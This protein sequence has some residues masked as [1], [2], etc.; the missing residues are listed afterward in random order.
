MYDFILGG[1]ASGKTTHIYKELIEESLRC[2]GQSFYLFVPEQYTL[3]AQQALA[4]MSP[5]GGILNIDVLSFTLLSYRVFSELGVKKPDILDDMTKS[6]LIRK[7]MRLKKDELRIYARKT[8]SQGFMEEIKQAIAEFCQYDIDTDRLR[9]LSGEGVSRRLSDKLSD[10]AA[11]YECFSDLLREG[12]CIPEEL[13]KLLLSLLPRSEYL[14]G[15]RVYFD[16]FTGYTPIQLR[17]IAHIL[18][19]AER[20]SF[21]VTIPKAELGPGRSRDAGSDTDIYWLSRDSISSIGELGDRGGIAHGEDLILDGTR[22]SPEVLVRDFEDPLRETEELARIIKKTVLMDESCRYRDIAVAVSDQSTYRDL[23]RNAFDRAGIPFFM[24]ENASSDQ[25][26]SASLLHAVLQLVIRG[27]RYDDLSRY[28]KNPLIKRAVDSSG[29]YTDIFDNYIRAR[30]IRGRRACEAPFTD[31]WRG[32]EGLDLD[33]LNAYRE[34]LMKPVLELHDRLREQRTIGD[35]AISLK[36]YMEAAGAEAADRELCQRLRSSGYVNEAAAEESFM[37]QC[38]LLLQRMSELMGEERSSI[39]AF[40]ELL[41][42]GLSSLKA[43]LIPQSMDMLTVGDLRRSRFDGIRQLYVLGANDG[44]IPRASEVRGIFTQQERD[45]LTALGLSLAPQSARLVSSENFYL[46]LLLHKP[47]DRLYIS[48]PRED[49]E[50]REL[51]PAGFIGELGERHELAEGETFYA[52]YEDALSAFSGLLMKEGE[53]MEELRALFDLLSGD[54]RTRDR[55]GTLLK[56]AL[57]RYEGA[58]MDGETARELYGGVLYGSVTRMESFERCAYAHFLRYG[59]RLM[60]RQEYDVEAADMGNLYHA[61]LELSFRRLSEQGLE[62]RDV[63]EEELEGIGRA[64]VEEVSSEYNGSIMNASARNVFLKEKVGRITRR[65]L[66][67]LRTQSRKGS[68]R[69]LSCELPFRLRDEGLELH[70][71]IDRVDVCDD[72]IDTYVRVIDYKSGR[73]RFDLSLIYH[74]LQMQ[75]ITYMD[76]AIG[77]ARRRGKGGRVLPAGLYYYNIDDPVVSYETAGEGD[78]AEDR[79]KDGI[80]SELRMNGL[81]NSDPDILKSLDEDLGPESTATSGVVPVRL[82]EGSI[83]PSSSMVCGTEGFLRLMER[84]EKRIKDDTRDILSGDIDIRPYRLGGRTGCDY[85]PYHSVCGFDT[86]LPGYGYR[87]LGSISPDRL[88]AELFGEDGEGH[89][90]D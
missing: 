57:F 18:H 61:A 27:Y 3:R 79:A 63:S 30:G 36:N 53:D 59:L 56:E 25:S 58:P 5:R 49:R 78:G 82:K 40:A 51:R 62:L 34:T 74:G 67:A 46:Y 23:I 86:S 69:T 88:R 17:I 10:I 11:I 65:T 52:S 39:K 71:R 14:R 48:W 76:A 29:V 9:Q 7:A 85:C 19:Q 2:P 8:D 60:E 24:D 1:A 37:E 68:Y 26:A 81:T 50:G 41:D 31:T 75:L 16:G 43:A 22:T 42:A 4:A 83:V 64:A 80:L 20:V 44:L 35:Y 70:G 55:V 15:S 33:G 28:I 87:R 84:T 13:P 90:V 47:S 38:L 45:E 72:S 77:E 89:A 54:E 73:T 66:W 21:A 12:E 32:A 6:L